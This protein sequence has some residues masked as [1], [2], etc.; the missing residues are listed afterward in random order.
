M[1]TTF[2]RIAVFCGSSSGSDPK[3]ADAARALGEE[4]ARRNIKLVYGGA[5]CL[6]QSLFC[7]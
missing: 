1:A 5:F 6:C 4:M 3:Y 7:G 2:G